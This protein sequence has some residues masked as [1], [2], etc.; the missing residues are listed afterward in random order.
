MPSSGSTDLLARR[1]SGALSAPDTTNVMIS[2]QA[3][4]TRSGMQ[5]SLSWAGVERRARYVARADRKTAVQIFNADRHAVY[6]QNAFDVQAVSLPLLA[7][8][9][10]VEAG[11]RHLW[12]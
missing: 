4:S 12:R 5:T 3:A 1:A 10:A 9:D 6:R 7:H 11:E 2:R 8:C